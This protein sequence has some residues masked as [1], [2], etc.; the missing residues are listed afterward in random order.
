M[1][2]PLIDGNYLTHG[3]DATAGDSMSTFQEVFNATQG[4]Y[5]RHIAE[6]QLFVQVSNGSATK[7]KYVVYLKETYHLVRHTSRALALGAARLDDGARGVRAWL[8]D[9]AKDEHGHELFC[10]K[11]IKNL[12]LDPQGITAGKPGPGSWGVVTQNYYMSTY[13]SP[14]GLL[15]V[16][17]ATEGM[18]SDLA[19]DLADALVA[20]YDI[21]ESAT[22][23]LRSHS[24][25][26]KRHYQE[27]QDAINSF[28]QSDD[29]LSAVIH[30][31]RMTLRYY[32][33]IFT[34]VAQ[35]TSK[36]FDLAD[37]VAA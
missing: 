5:N 21:P 28:V 8:I 32:G 20:R 9:Q 35:S 25:F 24:G 11:D 29:E 12:G 27:T 15:G 10:L 4:D 31:R 16:A 7:D 2:H 22:T 18:G 14:I 17:S 26:D 6:N 13:G 23:F 34:E 37:A 1:R 3:I 36:Y 19:G 30:A 33:Q